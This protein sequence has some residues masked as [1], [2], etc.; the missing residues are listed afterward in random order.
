MSV[1]AALNVSGTGDHTVITGVSGQVVQIKALFL[2]CGV[3]TTVTLK[4]GSSTA[5]TG[6]MTF[7]VGGQMNLPLTSM[8]V[9][10]GNT[11]D[12]FVINI[13]SLLGQVAGFIVYDIVEL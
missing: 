6:P 4:S 9:I 1:Y 11:S 13:G 7:T 10:Q 3:A 5:L 12:N 2:Q 8:V